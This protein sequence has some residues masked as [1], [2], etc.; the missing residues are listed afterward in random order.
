MMRHGES[1]FNQLNVF[2]GWCDV[3]LTVRGRVE[4]V[5]AGQLLRSR[6]IKAKRVCVAY[7]SELERSH[8]TCELVLAPS[9]SLT[10]S[11]LTQSHRRFPV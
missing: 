3:P 10:P 7:T 1:A 2:T 9:L 4:A 8:E 5:A 6:G 11:I